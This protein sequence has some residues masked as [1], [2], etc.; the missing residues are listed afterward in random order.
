[1]FTH[2]VQ[3]VVERLNYF[4][5]KIYRTDIDGGIVIKSNGNKLETIVSK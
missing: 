2:P 1:L 3:G 5:S 4:D